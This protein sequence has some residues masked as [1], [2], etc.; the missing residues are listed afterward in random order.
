MYQDK[1][2]CLS[3]KIKISRMMRGEGHTKPIP[4]PLATPEPVSP[5][6]N[7]HFLPYPRTLNMVWKAVTGATGYI[8]TV[9]FYSNTPNGKTW[10]TKAPLN[11][12]STSVTVDFPS[13]VP[14]RWSVSAVDSTGAHTQSPESQWSTFDFTVQIL[15][16]PKLLSPV[17]GQTFSNY[18][19]KTTL[20]WNPVPNATGYVVTVD[21]CPDRQALST[22]KWQNQIKTIVPTNSYTFDFKGAQPG[23]WC[24]FAIDSTNAHQQSEP[25]PWSNFN[26][27]V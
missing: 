11:V 3:D 1:V 24:V 26:Y 23:R 6:N 2:I 16:T 21:Y 12:T 15:E 13:N 17:N 9:Q 8:V 22:S 20:A 7:Q 10:L 14:G 27:T 5:I 19:R 4:T 18:P 25:S